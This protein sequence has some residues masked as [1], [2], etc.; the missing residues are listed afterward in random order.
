M[1]WQHFAPAACATTYPAQS[2]DDHAHRPT[3]QALPKSLPVLGSESAAAVARELGFESV[4]ELDHG[5]TLTL[6]DGRLRVTGTQ[7]EGSAACQPQRRHLWQPHAADALSTCCRPL[8]FTA[9]LPLP[10]EGALVGPPWSKR[11]LGFVFE[12]LSPDGG[13]RLYYEPHAD[14]VAASVAAVGQARLGMAG[15]M[16]G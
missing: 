13:I 8:V 15:M 12:E 9:P 3:L 2:I 7:G 1:L 5:Q 16:V 10:V 11:E 14:Y 4:F 6:C